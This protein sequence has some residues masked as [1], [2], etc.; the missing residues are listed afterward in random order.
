MH[1]NR[2]LWTRFLCINHCQFP[3]FWTRFLCIETEFFGLDFFVSTTANFHRSVSS[4]PSHSSINS[5]QQ[6]HHVDINSPSTVA[7]V[8]NPPRV[9][10]SQLDLSF[11][12]MGSL[13][14]SETQLLHLYETHSAH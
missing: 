8:P 6:Q 5:P 1:R 13:I 9:C 3:S 7:S 4:L 12:A 11:L 2:V 10:G 14:T